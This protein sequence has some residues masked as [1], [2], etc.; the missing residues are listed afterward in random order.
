MLDEAPPRTVEVAGR[1]VRVNWGWRAGVRLELAD[2]SDGRG[3]YRALRLMF[4]DSSGMLP[5]AVAQDAAAAFEA[6]ME[7]HRAGWERMPY[8]AGRRRRAAKPRRLIDLDAD[9][10][11]VAADF[12]RLYR[13]DLDLSR[14]HWWRFCGLVLSAART[15]GS[16]LHEAVAARS[17]KVAGAKGDERKRLE[18]LREAWALPPT[19]AEMRARARAEFD[20]W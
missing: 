15:P 7:W 12:Q 3:R 13:I 5:E 1:E 2:L 18:A 6:G 4:A 16:L 11:I 20:R 14:M 19:E 10:A 9:A 17:A 8:G